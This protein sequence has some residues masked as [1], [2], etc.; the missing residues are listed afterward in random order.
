MN[1]LILFGGGLGAGKDTMRELLIDKLGI[2]KEYHFSFALPLKN[3]ANRFIE[4]VKNG[5][6]PKEISDEFN[7]SIEDAL[8][9]IDILGDTPNL[10][11]EVNAR[12]RTAEVRRFLQYWGTDVRRKQNKNYW[13]DI[14][15]QI[16]SEKLAAGYTVIVTDGRFCNEYDLV[17]NLGGYTI[18]L[19]VSE[20]ERCK[21][22]LERDG[23]LPS[24]DAL[25]H[26]SEKDWKIY[27]KFT[28]KINSDNMTAE[29]T[30]D[31]I[32]KNVFDLQL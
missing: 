5:K 15:N 22:V 26:A 3:E 2:N 23:I 16:I 19:Y 17:N 9:G 30:A 21:R 28:Y 31:E 13:V 24:K 29:A 8:R 6:T 27:E 25:N 14:A 1:N 4:A 11:P 20:D 10:Y 18:C 12:S 32:I 7:I